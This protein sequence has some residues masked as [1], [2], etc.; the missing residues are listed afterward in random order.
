MLERLLDQGKEQAGIYAQS[1][2]IL[3]AAGMFA[4]L[5]A[6]LLLPIFSRML[7]K[8]E[9]VGEIVQLSHTLIFIP[10]VIL[11]ILVTFYNSDI[12]NWLYNEHIEASSKIF[13]LLMFGFIAISISYIFGTLLTANGNLK[14]LNLL[15]LSAVVMNILLNLILI[16]RYQAFGAAVSSLVTQAFIAATQVII[17]VIRFRMAINY[18]YLVMLVIYIIITFLT[19]W[20]C[21]GYLSNWYFGALVYLVIATAIPFIIRLLKFKDLLSLFLPQENTH[22]MSSSDEFI[23]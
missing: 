13:P 4:F 9:P 2:R 19:G 23:G 16:P 7:K 11:A 15:A 12:L 6:G 5:F 20:L 1:F 3:D 21:S 10:A 18:R 17:S 22:R 8:E 14:L